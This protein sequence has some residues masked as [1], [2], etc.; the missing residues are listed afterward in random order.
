[1]EE[2]NHCVKEIDEFIAKSNSLSSTTCHKLNCPC[3]FDNTL[4]IVQHPDIVVRQPAVIPAP[5][6]FGTE[7]NLSAPY[8]C[9]LPFLTPTVTS[10]V[11]V[12]YVSLSH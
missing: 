6:A 4:H 8:Q 5:K 9:H 3:R 7:S 2:L 10:P 11:Y 12:V 1:M